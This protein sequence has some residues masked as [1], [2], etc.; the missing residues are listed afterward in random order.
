MKKILWILPLVS[1]VSFANVLIEDFE[2]SSWDE[3]RTSLLG[4]KDV[5]F[6]YSDSADV[7][8]STELDYYSW[9]YEG[10]VVYV[11]TG[12]PCSGFRYAYGNGAYWSFEPYVK[13]IENAA[14]EMV[15][16]AYY[17]ML[18][19]DSYFMDED[20]EYVKEHYPSDYIYVRYFATNNTQVG[21]FSY[22]F[23]KAQMMYGPGN[24]YL[25]ATPKYWFVPYVAFGVK[26]AGNGVDYDLSKCTGIQYQYVGDGHKFRADIST[27]TD[28]NYH[29]KV[30]NQSE[31]YDYVKGYSTVTISWSQLAQESDW[32]VK[33]PF[34]ASKIKQLVWELK[35][36]NE[37]SYD[38]NAPDLHGKL[39]AGIS[40]RER[41]TGYLFIDN[42]TCLTSGTSI[43]VGP[44]S[45]S[46]AAK[47]ANSSSS[48]VKPA[49]GGSSE[50]NPTGGSSSAANPANDN[51]TALPVELA[52]GP[53]LSIHVQAD[54]IALQSSVPAKVEI[55]DY[56][57]REVYSSAMLSAGSNFVPF[58]HLI[59]GVY[60]AR[61]QA[62]NRSETFKIQVR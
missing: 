16:T 29:Y 28:D 18:K 23:G 37:E 50:A 15:D 46:S 3:T 14:G 4:D 30:V 10:E 42:V 35:G 38:R 26:T 47:P 48:V 19:T 6:S 36:G 9:D 53:A 7:G 31:S 59:K 39:I 60:I 57:G 51:S 25:I 33:R 22:K 27:V 21:G 56:Q 55:F 45:S 58:D 13:K 20:K 32:G 41:G 61:I 34:D 52:S 17:F 44:A 24:A 5:W 54:G 2:R 49:D 8:C 1:V 62:R 11:P 40:A 12:E 43:P